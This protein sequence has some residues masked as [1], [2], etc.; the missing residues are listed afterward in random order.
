MS[1]LLTYVP[2]YYR[3]SEVMQGLL[4]TQEVEVAMF[5]TASEA[6]QA[7][8]L[9][10]TATDLGLARW[11]TILNL[12]SHAALPVQQRRER[13]VSKLRGIGTV[14]AG[15]IRNVAESYAYGTVLVTEAPAAHEVKVTF[16]DERGI[17][18]NID[19]LKAAIGHIIPAHLAVAYEFTFT[20][21]G[22]IALAY[23][24]GTLAGSG[25]TWEQLKTVRL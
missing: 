7:Q 2:L 21:W 19:D 10:E 3:H 1:R 14:T 13:I 23:T 12:P 24:W 9:L 18:L 11:E 17:P 25:L 16:I 15:L 8:F 4:G 6:I 20:T 5:D 22:E